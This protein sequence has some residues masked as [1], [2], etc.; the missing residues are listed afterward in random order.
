MAEKK[1]V[2]KVKVL[3]LGQLVESQVANNFVFL[4]KNCVGHLN[5]LLILPVE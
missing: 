2:Y 1:K 4:N 3:K 5:T